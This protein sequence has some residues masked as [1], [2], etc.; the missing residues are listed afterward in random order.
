MSFI[1]FTVTGTPP[2]LVVDT[3]I[4]N[5]MAIEVGT[6]SAESLADCLELTDSK[7]REIA[8]RGFVAPDEITMTGDRLDSDFLFNYGVLV[9]TYQLLF[10]N[11]GANK[12]ND[13]YLMLM[14]TLRKDIKT[15]LD[16]TCKGCYTRS[17]ILGEEYFPEFTALTRL[18]GGKS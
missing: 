12:P 6:K 4:T 18:S 3:Q 14:Q 17:D 13:S 5:M 11:A 16:D 7:I 8:R 10:V 1:K 2:N 9:L 15:L